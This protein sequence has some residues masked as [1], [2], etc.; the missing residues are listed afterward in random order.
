MTD[1]VNI[2]DAK[3]NFSALVARAQS[4]E[5]IIIAQRGKP[6]CRLVPLESFNNLP[7]TPIPGKLPKEWEELD[8]LAPD[9]EW[10]ATIDESEGN[11]LWPSF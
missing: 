10:E 4:G 11:P 2:Y 1:M 6:A 9:S 8:L 7:R 5:E 3:A